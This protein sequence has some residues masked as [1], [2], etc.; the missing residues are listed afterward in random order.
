MVDV[1]AFIQSLGG[2]AA[3][4]IASPTSRVVMIRDS[5]ISRRLAWLYRQLT[6]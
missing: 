1:L 3:W 5:L 2:R 4:A 6:L